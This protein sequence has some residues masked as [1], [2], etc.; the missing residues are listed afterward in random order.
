MTGSDTVRVWL[1]ERDY[2]DRNLV[3]L[4]YA[5]PD[6]EREL[7][8]ELSAAV[9]RRS[10][11]TAARDVDPDRLDTVDDGDRRERYAH[12]AERVRERNDPD[13]AI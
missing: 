3:T 1:V 6:G 7:R 2:G 13:D 12:E 11:V 8:R 9:L 5:T 4:T 10:S